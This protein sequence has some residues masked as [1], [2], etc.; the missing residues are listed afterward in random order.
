MAI[1]TTPFL[2]CMLRWK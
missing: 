2:A 1:D